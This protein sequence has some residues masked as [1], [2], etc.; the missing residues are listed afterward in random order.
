MMWVSWDC[1]AMSHPVRPPPAAPS[2]FAA[3]DFE[4]PPRVAGASAGRRA[5]GEERQGEAGAKGGGREG[6]VSRTS[7]DHPA[8]HLEAKISPRREAGKKEFGQLGLVPV[9]SGLGLA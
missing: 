6:F 5:A 7:D 9:G 8:G 4:G 2:A 1:S 3:A